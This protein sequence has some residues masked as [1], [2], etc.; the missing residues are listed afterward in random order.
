MDNAT[1][2]DEVQMASVAATGS[3][4]QSIKIFLIRLAICVFLLSAWQFSA[5]RLLDD[6]WLSRPSAV[7]ARLYQW[8]VD[9]TLP[10]HTWITLQ[11]RA[12][13]RRYG[14]DRKP[15]RIRP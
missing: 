1:P 15:A 2:Q 5:G 13:R 11:A 3:M 6:F 7:A 8:S 12:R 14:R 9:G 4:H 10:Y